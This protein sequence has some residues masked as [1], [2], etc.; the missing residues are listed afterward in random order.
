MAWF[1][2][3]D[4]WWSHPKILQ[5]SDS[6]QALWMRAGSWSM[7]HLTDGDVP[8]FALPLLGAKPKPVAE[9]VSVGLWLEVPTG[10][11]FHDWAK[12]QPSR[13]SVE[14]ERE[15]AAERKRVSRVKSQG[16]SRRDSGSPSAFPDPTRPDPTPLAKDSE[17]IGSGTTPFCSRH[18]T[19][20]DEPCGPCRTARLAFESATKAEKN[21][22]TPTP[23][24]ASD[25]CVEHDWLLRSQCT[26]MEHRNG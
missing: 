15:S 11:Q 9:L 20:T 2:V 6:A 10:Y 7:K 19:G 24:R 21:K 8:T 5:L 17:V 12:Y 1:K 23:P 22:P 25:Y 3:D 4:G 18:P 16:E 26:E 14:R 13:E